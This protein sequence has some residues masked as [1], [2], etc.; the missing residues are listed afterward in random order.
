MKLPC[1]LWF[2]GLLTLSS[3]FLAGCAAP[4]GSRQDPWRAKVAELRIGLTT[5]DVRELFGEPTEQ[6]AGAEGDP[7]TAVWI[8]EDRVRVNSTMQITGVEDRIYVDPITGDERTVPEPV[9]NQVNQYADVELRLEW[10][11]NLLVKWQERRKT[12]SDF[13]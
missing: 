6:K 8:Y 10:A 3:L 5:N 9:Y 1:H 12:T 11:G 4:F 7:I 2:V 13:Q